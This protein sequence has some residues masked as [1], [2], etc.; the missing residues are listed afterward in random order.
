MPNQPTVRAALSDLAGRALDTFSETTG[1]V[2]VRDR[3][4]QRRFSH[5]Y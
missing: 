1:F 4:W 5:L 3:L 2:A